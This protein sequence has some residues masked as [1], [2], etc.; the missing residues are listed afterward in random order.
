MLAPGA[1]GLDWLPL[2]VVAKREY[3]QR[4]Q[5]SLDFSTGACDRGS[6]AERKSVFTCAEEGLPS[7]PDIHGRYDRCSPGMAC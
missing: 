6:I 7:Q 3:P 2:Q 5:E 4:L 1:A